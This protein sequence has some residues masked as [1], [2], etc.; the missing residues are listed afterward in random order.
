MI[1]RK[2][3]LLQTKTARG[4]NAYILIFFSEIFSFA[5]LLIH[6]IKNFMIAF[7]NFRNHKKES[8]GL[9]SR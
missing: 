4:N 5:S 6:S 1:F 9:G 3:I 2:V 8:G 7:H